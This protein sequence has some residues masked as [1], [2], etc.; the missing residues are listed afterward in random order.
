MGFTGNGRT[1]MVVT[2]SPNMGNCEHT[3]NTLRYGYRVKELGNDSS[4]ASRRSS[5]GNTLDLNRDF[6]N[7]GSNRNRLNVR[8]AF[9][10]RNTSR[11]GD[12]SSGMS[13]RSSGVRK[14]TG[15]INS[16]LVRRRQSKNSNRGNERVS[17]GSAMAKIESEKREEE[18]L[19]SERVKKED[20]VQ[21]P[22]PAEVARDSEKNP[23]APQ[24]VPPLPAVEK[25]GKNYME[26]PKITSSSPPRA[27]S[28][29]PEPESGP[30]AVDQ[31]PDDEVETD[32]V[33]LELDLS[34][35]HQEL[36]STILSEEEDLV[37]SHR[38]HIHS[39]MNLVKQEMAILN[40]VDMPGAKIDDYVSELGVVLDQKLEQ[41][42]KLKQQLKTFKTHLVDEETLHSSMNITLSPKHIERL[43]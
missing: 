30:A 34:Q 10:G 13:V 39:M 21:V 26:D 40:R 1:V 23:P 14:S 29:P 35:E 16:D 38:E 36:V 11:L 7:N 17:V 33:T 3:L 18:V 43:V 12:K 4:S 37:A 27:R 20:P 24:A 19:A 15:G 9:K 8:N 31:D 6:G 28:V 5:A 25:P 22:H 42:T 32:T 41:V 2:I